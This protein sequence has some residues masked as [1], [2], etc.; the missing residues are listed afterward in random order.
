MTMEACAPY[1]PISF[2]AILYGITLILTIEVCAPYPPISFF[3]ILYGI[4]LILTIEVCAPYPPI[5]GG[6]GVGG[7]SVG[8][9]RDSW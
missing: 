2:F 5:R 1:P 4:T 7:S 9:A 3:P 6:G 8:R